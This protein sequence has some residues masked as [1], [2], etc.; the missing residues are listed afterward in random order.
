MLV[1]RAEVH[2]AA[3]ALHAAEASLRVQDSPEALVLDRGLENGVNLGW[4]LPPGLEG[5][6]PIIA[7]GQLLLWRHRV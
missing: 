2:L 7:E 1:G 3:A 5:L 4:V 6:Q